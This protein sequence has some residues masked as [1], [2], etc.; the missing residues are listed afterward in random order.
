MG[1][2]VE[3]DD[4]ECKVLGPVHQS[5]LLALV[6]QLR[7]SSVYHLAIFELFIQLGLE[8]PVVHSRV[9]RN[10]SDKIVAAAHRDA[11]ECQ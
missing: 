3:F 5:I 6:G 1:G 10:I 2:A 7:V 8:K 11:S 9:A 4:F